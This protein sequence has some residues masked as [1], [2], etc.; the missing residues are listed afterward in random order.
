MLLL[1]CIDKEFV[2]CKNKAAEL[3]EKSKEEN[4]SDVVLKLR[5]EASVMI[6]KA[7]LWT[8]LKDKTKNALQDPWQ[9][10]PIYSL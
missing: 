3:V 10:V 8:E 2:K 5:G 7:K 4:K 6:D 9:P 1:E